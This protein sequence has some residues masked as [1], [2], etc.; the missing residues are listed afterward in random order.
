M[1][2]PNKVKVG[3][4]VYDVLRPRDTFINNGVECDGLHDFSRATIK[5][6]ESGIL[7]YQ[8]TVFLHEL[9]HAIIEVYCPDVSDEVNE[10]LAQQLSKGLYQVIEDN[11]EIFLSPEILKKY[12]RNDLK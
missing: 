10:T 1:I 2:I 9:I 6:T 11:P 7:D 8:K 5:V 12:E 4:Y 3:G